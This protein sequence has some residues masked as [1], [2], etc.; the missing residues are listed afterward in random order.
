VF[1]APGGCGLEKAILPPPPGLI[2]CLVRRHPPWGIEGLFIGRRRLGT[3]CLRSPEVSTGVK[4]T[5]APKVLDSQ[6]VIEFAGDFNG[7][8]GWQKL[9]ATSSP[10]HRPPRFL[11]QDMCQ[12]SGLFPRGKFAAAWGT[13]QRRPR[14]FSLNFVLRI[15]VTP[16]GT[17]GTVLNRHEIR[18]PALEMLKNVCRPKESQRANLFF[19]SSTSDVQRKTICAKRR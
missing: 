10:K 4:K 8:T 1:G 9:P 15:E 12:V 16:P 3:E 11:W 2:L 17:I 6:A 5:R 19:P 18:P 7:M 14:A 13:I